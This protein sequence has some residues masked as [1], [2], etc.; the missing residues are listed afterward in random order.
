MVC[1][2]IFVFAAA[3]VLLTISSCTVT[4][5]AGY[6]GKGCTTAVNAQYAGTYAV[7]DTVVNG[8]NKQVLNYKLSISSPASTPANI[9]IYN[10]HNLGGDSAV[11]ASVSGNSITIPV[12]VVGDT[13]SLSNGMGS[14]N[15]STI[16]IYYTLSDTNLVQTCHAVGIK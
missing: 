14:I 12:V 11:D 5:D 15:D 4:C 7:I 8:S 10:L 3:T 6:E 9:V 1:R 13:L 16:S 2:R